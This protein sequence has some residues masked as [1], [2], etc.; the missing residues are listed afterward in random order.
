MTDFSSGALASNLGDHYHLLYAVRRMINMLHPRSSL[1]LLTMEGV[2]RED[3]ALAKLTKP[4]LSADVVEYYGG[5][6]F[7]DAKRVIVTQLKYSF[8][9]ANQNWTLKRLCNLKNPSDSTSSVIGGLA[10]LFARYAALAHFQPAKL[11]FQIFTNQPLQPKLAKKLNEIEQLISGKEGAEIS[12]TLLPL[13]GELKD[14]IDQL[15]QAVELDWEQLGW[16]L[17]CWNRNGFSQ[18]NLNMIEQIAF[19]EMKQYLDVDTAQY[20]NNLLV[21]ALKCAEAGERNEITVAEVFY[22]LGFSPTDF[23]P[24]PYR[25]DSI[26]HYQLTKTQDDL[27]SNI[28]DSSSGFIVLHGN[29]GQ[30]KS[31]EL[32][33]FAQSSENL[34]RV[35][36]YDCWAGGTAREPG[37]ERYQLENFLTEII[38]EL[39]AF[40]QT[41]ILANLRDLR[42]GDVYQSLLERFNKA[43]RK[44]SQTAAKRRHRLVIMIDAADEAVK[45]YQKRTLQRATSSCFLDT[46]WE[47]VLPDNCV[48]VL[49]TRTENIDKLK[50]PQDARLLKVTGFSPEQ[51]K[52]YINSYLPDFDMN[53]IKEIHT[54]SEGNPRIIQYAIQRFKEEKPTDIFEF[55][56]HVIRVPLEESY[57]QACKDADDGTDTIEKLLVALNELREPEIGVLAE[58]FGMSVNECQRLLHKLYGVRILEGG[59]LQFANKN[60]EDFVE[61]LSM[62]WRKQIV[63]LISDY[64]NEAIGKSSYAFHNFVYHAF[65]AKEYRNLVDKQLRDHLSKRIN[66]LAPYPEDV[67]EDIQYSLLAAMELGEIDSAITFLVTAAEIAH[68]GGVFAAALEDHIDLAVKFDYHHRL[69]KYLRKSTQEDS[70]VGSYLSLSQYFAANA[71]EETL[72][73]ALMKECSQIIREHNSR[74][75]QGYNW[76]WDQ[77]KNFTL[78]DCYA[79]GL[80]EGLERLYRNWTPQEPIYITYVD[81]VAEY[82]AGNQSSSQVLQEIENAAIGD[83]Q[84]VFACTGWLLSTDSAFPLTEA[85]ELAQNLARI[86][87]EKNIEFRNHRSTFLSSVIMRF[88]QIG[89]QLVDLAPLIDLWK[90]RFPSVYDVLH[91]PVSNLTDFLRWYVLQELLGTT[92]FELS[93]FVPKNEEHKNDFTDLRQVLQKLYPA[94][95]AYIDSLMNAG[96]SSVVSLIDQGLEPWKDG[97]VYSPTKAY[98]FRSYVYECLNA[99]VVLPDFHPE[100]VEKLLTSTDEVLKEHY[101]GWAE[102]TEI[103]SGKSHYQ[104]HAENLIYRQADIIVSER[105]PARDKVDMLLKLCRLLLKMQMVTPAQ[106]MFNLSRKYAEQWDYR[107]FGRS[108]ALLKTS[109]TLQHQGGT[110]SRKQAFD[111]LN[112]FDYIN[113]VSNDE[114]GLHSLDIFRI[115]SCDHPDAVLQAVRLSDEKEHIEFGEGLIAVGQGIVDQHTDNSKGLWTLIHLSNRDRWSDFV[116]NIAN[117]ILSAQPASNLTNLI[118]LWTKK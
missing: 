56:S 67:L 109:E 88:I 74:F 38:N 47:F 87:N 99:I 14:T 117:H 40:Y 13:T 97:Y 42:S 118:D 36:V 105:T 111:L 86:I 50:I 71:K 92:D 23:F 8:A 22:Q 48:I 32:Q 96:S 4:M 66:Q 84:K 55:I 110:L 1:L 12:Q 21:Y 60:F 24:A 35:I 54:L 39:D 77:I 25:P 107:A 20:I 95:K 27:H 98:H 34:R 113:E 93:E 53:I 64:C 100:I 83:S 37:F 91:P 44:A 6:N 80:R 46:L 2:A 85:T 58:L 33:Y 94:S 115:V 81:V 75:K 31:T 41:N 68:G 73:Q 106:D 7:Q 103:L 112:V 79:D 61:Q 43:L 76:E 18:P 17:R 26:D 29:G 57:R 82:D 116:R 52:N 78:H 104:S 51:T 9:H 90:P 19:E 5:M 72:V 15:K 108:M 89:V 69:I 30:G 114:R 70:R 45:T 49:S 28:Q 10:G 65:Q 102:I 101:K 63:A 16:F 11:E 3:I 62:T 59:E